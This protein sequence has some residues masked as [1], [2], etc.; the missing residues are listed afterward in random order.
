MGIVHLIGAAAAILSLAAGKTYVKVDDSTGIVTTEVTSESFA[1]TVL[2]CAARAAWTDAPYFGTQDLVGGVR[3]YLSSAQ[4]SEGSLQKTTNSNDRVWRLVRDQPASETSTTTT[5][6]ASTST[7]TTALSTTTATGTTTAALPTTTTTTGGLC[8]ACNTAD[9]TTWGII[10]GQVGC[11]S[12]NMCSANGV[13]TQSCP[14]GLV[15]S[16]TKNCDWPAAVNK[17]CQC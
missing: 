6:T 14:G 13:T 16:D 8:T 15:M 10:P 3:C 1:V 5:S 2:Q 11:S 12:Y 17:V 4:A 7:T 9:Q